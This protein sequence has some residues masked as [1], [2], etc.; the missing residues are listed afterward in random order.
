LGFASLLAMQLLGR[1]QDKLGLVLQ[2]SDLG[3]METIGDLDAYIQ[4]LIADPGKQTGGKK[5]EQKDLPMFYL[6]YKS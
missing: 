2:F 1:L 6:F 3:T 5:K 4:S